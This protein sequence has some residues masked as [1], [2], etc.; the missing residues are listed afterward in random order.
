MVRKYGGCPAA[1]SCPWPRAFRGRFTWIPLLRECSFQSWPFPPPFTRKTMMS[2]GN[3]QHSGDRAYCTCMPIGHRQGK[4]IQTKG[5]NT[6]LFSQT[7]RAAGTVVCEAELEPLP[8]D[9]TFRQ[10]N[11]WPLCAL[12]G[13]RNSS[14]GRA[15]GRPGACQIIGRRPAIQA[16]YAPYPANR[17]EAG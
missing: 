10:N 8:S 11:G 17:L 7:A 15:G 4:E 5:K 16:A 3:Q 14:G 2:G 6:F 1:G 12:E 13:L 9:D